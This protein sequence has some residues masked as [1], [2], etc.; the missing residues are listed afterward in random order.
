MPILAKYGN[1]AEGFGITF[2]NG[3][4]AIMKTKLLAT[5]KKVQKLFKIVWE[6]NGLLK[7]ALPTVVVSARSIAP[8]INPPLFQY[9]I[10]KIYVAGQN[11][12]RIQLLSEIKTVWNR[13]YNKAVRRA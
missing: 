9:D 4:Q 8:L 1:G 10:F 12:G 3:K 7:P 13:L 6:K 5:T 2:A 11:P